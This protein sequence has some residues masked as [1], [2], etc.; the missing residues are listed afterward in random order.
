MSRQRSKSER[1]YR[2]LKRHFI[3]NDNNHHSFR[4]LEPILLPRSLKVRRHEV[5]DL[6]ATWRLKD[7]SSR[8]FTA[9][10]GNNHHSLSLTT[11]N[12][13]QY[14]FNQHPLR[15]MKTALDYGA[16]SVT[17]INDL[18]LRGTINNGF[19]CLSES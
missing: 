16:P 5:R 18:P 2:H 12:G 11:T 14:Q 7:P 1:Y 8:V 13:A 19:Y 4:Q 10:F 9:L 3:R 15:Q 17:T 6:H